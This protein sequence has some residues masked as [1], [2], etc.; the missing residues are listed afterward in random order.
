MTVLTVVESVTAMCVVRMKL[1]IGGA[2]P[3]DLRGTTRAR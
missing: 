2:L 3:V 1:T